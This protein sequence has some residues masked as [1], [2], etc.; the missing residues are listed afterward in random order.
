MA[1]LRE[2]K[3]MFML[4]LNIWAVRRTRLLEGLEPGSQSWAAAGYANRNKEV[5]KNKQLQSQLLAQKA[6]QR[7][8]SPCLPS[9]KMEADWQGKMLFAGLR[10]KQVEETQFTACSSEKEDVEINGG[11][12]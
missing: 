1:R 8:T 7:G 4:L 10:N 3:K 5:I 6:A 11:S 9:G 12:L 2:K